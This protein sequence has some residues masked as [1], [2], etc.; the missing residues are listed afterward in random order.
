MRE[1][2]TAR[3]EYF[4]SCYFRSL[5]SGK[6]IRRQFENEP[7]SSETSVLACVDSEIC[8]V[9]FY[10]YIGRQIKNGKETTWLT[11]TDRVFISK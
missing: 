9:A 2:N 6:T 10:S 1:N 11:Y 3:I 5:Y 4:H 8:W 7:S